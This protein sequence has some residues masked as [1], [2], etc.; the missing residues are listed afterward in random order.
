MGRISVAPS[1]FDRSWSRDFPTVNC[2]LPYW[3]DL[4]PDR[5]RLQQS[6]DMSVSVACGAE[7]ASEGNRP[8]VL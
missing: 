7:G 6:G 8:S 3:A 2:G 4:R 5:S 1:V